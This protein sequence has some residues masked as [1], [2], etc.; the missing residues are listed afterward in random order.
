MSSWEIQTTHGQKNNPVWFFCRYALLIA[1]I[2]WFWTLT[3][4]CFISLR[5][6]NT[7]AVFKRSVGDPNLSGHRTVIQLIS[8]FFCFFFLLLKKTF[9]NVDLHQNWICRI[10]RL[11]AA[12]LSAMA[13]LSFLSFFL[14]LHTL[15]LGWICWDIRSWQH[16]QFV[17]FRKLT[18]LHLL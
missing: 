9:C 12:V 5:N 15:N 13:L 8:F 4:F 14:A 7:A 6:R 1:L 18:K 17:Q 16:L 11:L 2:Y 10:L 3:N